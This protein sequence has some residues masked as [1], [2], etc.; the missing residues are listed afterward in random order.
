MFVQLQYSDKKDKMDCYEIAST[1][2]EEEN[3]VTG[4]KYNFNLTTTDYINKC[5]R[6]NKISIMT[7]T[8]NR[9]N[10]IAFYD[11]EKNCIVILYR[12]VL[13]Q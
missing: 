2:Q 5:K 3:D 13:Q 6:K 12:G 8:Y 10:E 1:P 9:I 7:I 11:K 4:K